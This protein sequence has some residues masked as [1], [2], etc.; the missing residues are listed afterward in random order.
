MKGRILELIGCV[1]DRGENALADHLLKLTKTVGICDNKN[2]LLY[3][4]DLERAN[5]LNTTDFTR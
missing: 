1:I 5:S 4:L 3:I 2:Q